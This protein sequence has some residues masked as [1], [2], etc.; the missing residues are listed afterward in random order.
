MQVSHSRGGPGPQAPVGHPVASSSCV[1]HHSKHKRPDQGERETETSLGAVA[2]GPGSLQDIHGCRLKPGPRLVTQPTCSR[3]FL[4]EPLHGPGQAR[5]LPR[6]VSVPLAHLPRPGVWAEFHLLTVKQEDSGWFL[7]LVLIFILQDGDRADG[8]KLHRL[9]RGWRVYDRGAGGR[10]AGGHHHSWAT[11]GPCPTPA[12]TGPP[13]G[14]SS[15]ASLAHCQSRAAY[16]PSTTRSS[17]N[18]S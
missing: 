8:V 14:T 13:A 9:F 5:R 16:P 12:G 18:M 3:S 6:L 17:S 2:L 11:H 15:G 10:R 1:R 4:R 7:F